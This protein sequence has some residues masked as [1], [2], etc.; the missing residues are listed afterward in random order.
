[1]LTRGAERSFLAKVYGVYAAKVQ[2]MGRAELAT[3]LQHKARE[4]CG[5]ERRNAPGQARA[6][7]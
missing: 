4:N 5:G 2:T 6:S 7:R 3:L 1:V